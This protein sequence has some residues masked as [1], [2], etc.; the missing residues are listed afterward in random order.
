MVK[1][2]C[3][4]PE[5]GP[6]FEGRIPMRS[7]VQAMRLLITL[8]LLSS[9]GVSLVLAQTKPA[10][11]PPALLEP[12]TVEPISAAEF[13][14]LLTHY[15]GKVVLVNLWATWCA[16]CLKELPELARLQEQY[17]AQGLQ[18]ITITLDEPDILETRVKRIWRERAASLPAYLQT[19]AAPDKFVSVIDPAWNEIM[20]TNYLLDRTGQLKATLT[21]G[22][23]LAEFEAAL[24]PLL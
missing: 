14:Q 20:P 7:G 12:K 19:E 17:R 1:A 11:L 4:Q 24:K 21:G 8:L 2:G 23:T 13:R 16:P 18:V 15:Q 3:G 6:W 9:L 22:K 10:S 5:G